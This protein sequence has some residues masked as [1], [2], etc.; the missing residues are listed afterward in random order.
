MNIILKM[1]L[2]ED[3]EP[4][5]ETAGAF[6]DQ[7]L[8]HSNGET[9]LD[10]ILLDIM[11]GDRKLVTIWDEDEMIAAGVLSMSIFPNKKVCHISLAGG[12]RMEDWCDQSLP[13]IEKIAKEA[14]AD[15]IR[16]QGRR[17]WLRRFKAYGYD[18]IAT[19]IGKDL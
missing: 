8:A 4:V 13:T 7:A 10:H 17:G 18:E 2:P 15:A 5:W 16:I 12:I 11:N 9:D 1:V 6:I 3:V 19:V 14:G